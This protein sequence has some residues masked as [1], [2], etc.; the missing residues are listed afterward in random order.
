MRVRTLNFNKFNR[1]YDLKEVTNFNIEG[2]GTLFDPSIFGYGEERM[3]RCGYINLGGPFVDPPTFD[4][5]RRL[6][7]ELQGI[8][9][10]TRYYKITKTGELEPANSDEGNTGLQWFYDNYDKIK[11]SKFDE[12][13]GNK[14]QTRKMKKAYTKLKRDDFFIKNL[15]VIPL[16][17]RDIDT[18]SG[19]SMKI[20][21]LNQLY[22]D[23]IK[24]CN[25]KKRV[26]NMSSMDDSF[27]NAKIQ[28]LIQGVYEYI[29]NTLFGKE[30][31]QRQL[32]MGRSVDNCSRIVITAPEVKP[33]NVIGKCAQNLDHV[34]VPLHHFISGTP[35]HTVTAVHMILRTF[36]ERGLLGN[37]DV[38]DFEAFYTDEWIEDQIETYT[39]TYSHRL[40]NVPTPN[41]DTIKLRFVFDDEDNSFKSDDIRNLSFIDLFYLASQ[42]YVDNIRVAV[43]RYPIIGKDSMLF[44]KPIIATFHK[45]VGNMK[46]YLPEGDNLIYEYNHYPDAGKFQG[47]SISTDTFADTMSFSNTYLAG[48]DG[49]YDGDKVSVKYI[50]SKEA[51]KEIDDFNNTPISVLSIDGKPTR[52][53]HNEAMQGIYNLTKLEKNAKPLNDK[54]NNLV[55]ETFSKDDYTLAEILDILGQYSCS[56]LVNFKGHNKTTLGRVVFNEVVFN[57]LGTKHKWIEKDVTSGVIS[58]INEH[59]AGM[60]VRKEITIDDYKQFINKLDQLGFGVCTLTASTISYEMLIKDDPVWNKKRA[61]VKAKYQEGISNGDMVAMSNYQDEMI[62]FAKQHYAD[63]VM[64]DMYNSG[65]KPKWGNDFKSLKVSLGAAPSPTGEINLIESSL[66][67]G[68]KTSEVIHNTNMQITGAGGRALDTQQGGYVVKKFQAAFQS[69]YGIRGDCGSKQYLKTIDDNPTDLVGRYIKVGNEEIL[70]TEENVHKYL[71]KEVLKRSPLFCKNKSGLCSHCVGETMFDLMGA[72]RVN[73]G[74]FVSIIGSRLLGASMKSTHD[75]NQK[76]ADISTINEFI[77]SDKD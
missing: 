27:I 2:M 45:N 4:V 18:S 34:K 23:L 40:D 44:G 73:I 11:L 14:I 12:T 54:L 15:I 5:S 53:I 75:M 10:G 52:S 29:S 31:A 28:G 62:D 41:G 56:H 35:V 64:S 25:F 49:D 67:D 22:I 21:E 76:M 63:D 60:L 42:M 30:G 66:K 69:T 38:D 77:I 33:N 70:V 17:Y 51:I 20:D 55:K 59:Y 46:I 57:H 71:G 61:E 50:Y 48:L 24:A 36:L 3:V 1:K 8:V 74:F 47:T 26:S 43:T 19:N 72:D 7:R 13:E 65:A 6:F 16:H 58:N 39:V 9:D 37:I 32:A 68:L